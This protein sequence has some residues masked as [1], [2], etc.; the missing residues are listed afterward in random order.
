MDKLNK[1]GMGID[2]ESPCRKSSIM[3]RDLDEET[4]L[5][6][7]DTKHVHVLNKTA[8]LVWQMCDGRH[9]VADMAESVARA[10]SLPPGEQDA[11]TRIKDDVRSI[12][13]DFEAQG[14]VE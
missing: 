7:P 1:N 2:K 13:N 8:L 3:V 14:M 4:I 11:T 9:Y 5:Y 12:I 10:C 6:N